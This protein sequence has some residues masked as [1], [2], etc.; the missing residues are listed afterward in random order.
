MPNDEQ[1][2]ASILLALAG[3]ATFAAGLWGLIFH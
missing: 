2:V 1:L 3:L